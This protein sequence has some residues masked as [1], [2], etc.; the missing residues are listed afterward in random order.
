M[1]E[2]CVRACACVYVCVCHKVLLEKLGGKRLDGIPRC[3]WEDNFKVDLKY[4]SIAWVGFIWL[5]TQ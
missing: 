2:N 3:R 1:Y 5:K 4:I